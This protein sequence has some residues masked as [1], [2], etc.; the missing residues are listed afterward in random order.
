MND[1]HYI[2]WVSDVW[3]PGGLVSESANNAGKW[4]MTALP[5]WTAGARP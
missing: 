5:Q 3:A 4:T 1:G 2:T